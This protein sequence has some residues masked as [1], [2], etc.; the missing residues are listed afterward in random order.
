M[1]NNRNQAAEIA[2]M[3]D[4]FIAI[5]DGEEDDQVLFLAA[6]RMW[7]QGFR[8]ADFITPAKSTLTHLGAFVVRERDELSDEQMGFAS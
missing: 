4:L 8:P 7:D 2:R 6:I 3:K 5:F 1:R